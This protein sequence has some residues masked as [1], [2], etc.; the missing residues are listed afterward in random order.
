MSSGH[1]PRGS[2]EGPAGPR[3]GCPQ[4]DQLSHTA[5]TCRG[6]ASGLPASS[7]PHCRSRRCPPPQTLETRPRE[8]SVK[9]ACRSPAF[10]LRGFKRFSFA[11]TCASGAPERA[12]C[13]RWEAG[14]RVLS[15]SG[16]G[17]V[18]PVVRS[19]PS[20]ACRGSASV[21]LSSTCFS[22]AARCRCP[23]PCGFVTVLGVRSSAAFLPSPRPF[24]AL[25]PYVYTAEAARPAWPQPRGDFILSSCV[26]FVQNWKEATPLNML[27]FGNS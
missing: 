7:A 27:I 24:A 14:S 26:E 13:S 5:V 25:S 2:S 4:G 20:V 23:R 16:T 1:S 17:S 11:S 9:V 10:L 19:A 8:V 18:C 15:V 3:P 12:F 6:G 21:L 22:V